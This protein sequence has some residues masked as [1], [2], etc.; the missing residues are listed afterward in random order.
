M[1]SVAHAG[2]NILDK[3]RDGVF[4]VTPPIISLILEANDRIK[5]IIEELELTGVEP[6]GDDTEI[7]GKLNYCAENGK[8]R[9][10]NDA[11]AVAPQAEGAKET[12]GNKTPDLD[13]EIDFDP[14][15]APSAMIDTEVADAESAPEAAINVTKTPDLDE[16]ID[17]EPI[18]APG[19]EQDDAVVAQ[20]DQSTDM[21]PLTLSEKVKERAVAKGL[22]TVSGGD[23][24]EAK[25][26]S[27]TKRG[28]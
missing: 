8:I 22:A 3:L 4:A 16:E 13:G 23:N 17:F 19:V 1:E 9:D 7:I 28:Y 15:P 27:N 6:E 5:E 24:K 20:G 11:S 18:L 2:E 12:G 26:G 10:P 25:K 14:V 21:K